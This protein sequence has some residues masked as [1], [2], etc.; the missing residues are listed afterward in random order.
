MAGSHI[1]NGIQATDH[2]YVIEVD[3]EMLDSA[4]ERRT[5][6]AAEHYQDQLDLIEQ[7]FHEAKA[8][9]EFTIYLVDVAKR[10]GYDRSGMLKI[11]K[12][13]KIPMERRYRTKSLAWATTFEGAT[14]LVEEIGKRGV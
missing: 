1:Q 13:M 5:E 11:A 7:S 12:R 3:P 8:R 9:D 14:R 6:L 2:S 4:Q 10:I